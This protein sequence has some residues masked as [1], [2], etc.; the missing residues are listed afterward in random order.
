M[1][2]QLQRQAARQSAAQGTNDH[3]QAALEEG[4]QETAR[5]AAAEVGRQLAG[6]REA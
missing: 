1:Q 3:L 6:S 2:R 5:T 4:P